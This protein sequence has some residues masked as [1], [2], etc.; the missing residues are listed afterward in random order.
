VW[1]I[2]YFEW[3]RLWQ[4]LCGHPFWAEWHGALSQKIGLILPITTWIVLDL[5][6]LGDFWILTIKTSLIHTTDSRNI[7]KNQYCKN[8]GLYC[9]M[10]I[11]YHQYLS[12]STTPLLCADDNRLLKRPAVLMVPSVT[13]IG[14]NM[15]VRRPFITFSWTALRGSSGN[16]Q[17]QC[18]LSPAS[19]RACPTH[20]LTCSCYFSCL[21]LSWLP[22]WI[23]YSSSGFPGPHQNQTNLF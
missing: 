9:G 8:F 15:L 2:P 18:S 7:V 19:D 5:L 11:G 23:L 10:G 13:L 22:F 17:S 3:F 4:G 21:A 1:I 16:L 20:C 6:R 14:T 12:S